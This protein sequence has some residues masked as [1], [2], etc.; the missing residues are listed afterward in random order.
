MVVRGFDPSTVHWDDNEGRWGMDAFSEI[1]DVTLL[2]TG[3]LI[4]FITMIGAYLRSSRR[5]PCLKSFENFHV[6]LERA[7]GKVIWG[8]LELEATGF[9]LLYRDSV[10]DSHHLESSYVMYGS[11]FGEIQAIYRYVD[12]LS[13]EDLEHRQRDLNRYFHPG[14]VVRL[15]RNTQHFFTLASDSLTEVLGMVMG[16]LRK[17]AGRYIGEVT[18]DQFLRFSTAV[19]GSVGTTFD[20]LLERF[21][22]DKIVVELL[23]GDSSHEHVAVFKNYSAD[24][25]ELLDV[26]YPEPH[27]YHLNGEKD[28]LVAKNMTIERDGNLL[29][30][31]NQSTHPVLIQSLRSS[32]AEDAV[33]EMLNVVVDGGET[34]LLHP[35]KLTDQ[36]ALMVSLVRELDMIVPRTRCLI[37]HRADR[38]REKMIPEMVFDIG[39][40]LRG[41]S[42]LNGKIERLR[43]E[44]EET[45]DSAILAANL[46]TLLMQ[47]QQFA[48]AQ[49]LLEQAYKARY[50]LPD[51]GKRTLMLLHE[52]QRRTSKSPQ[53]PGSVSPVTSEVREVGA[54]ET[55]GAAEGDVATRIEVGN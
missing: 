3:G 39:V 16:R 15:L 25:F 53:R 37:R 26:Q 40:M 50:S 23:E 17:P 18:D 7:N 27:S 12:D 11:E 20:P 45:P 31:T 19:V 34:V 36:S 13:K 5:D 4:I 8:E 10:Q 43:K 14:P 48:E 55:V 44:L 41:E 22:G 35:A 46:G 2:A 6:T 30:V 33:E 21:I 47:Q 1:F 29:R 42:R 49:V 51:N 38:Y 24:F 54:A 9:E 32:D 28:E 52:L